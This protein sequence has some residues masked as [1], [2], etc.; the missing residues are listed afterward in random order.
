MTKNSFLSFI[1]LNCSQNIRYACKNLIRESSHGYLVV[2]PGKFK[3]FEKY[4]EFSTVAQ[5]EDN[6]WH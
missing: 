2:Y 3:Q 1:S 6:P 5:K 4:H